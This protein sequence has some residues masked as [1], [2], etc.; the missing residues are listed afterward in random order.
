MA[1]NSGG[2]LTEELQLSSARHNFDQLFSFEHG[3]RPK[4]NTRANVENVAP[5]LAFSKSPRVELTG[6]G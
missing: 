5:V 6:V 4:T 2:K 1:L 3:A